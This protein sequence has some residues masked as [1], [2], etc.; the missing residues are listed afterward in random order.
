MAIF[1][2][3]RLGD[4]GILADPNP[5]DLPPNA[6]SQGNNL[7]FNDGKISRSPVFK[8]VLNTT[9]SSPSFLFTYLQ[10]GQVDKVGIANNDGSLYF[11][12][13]G[14]EEDVTP[15]SFTPIV[16]DSPH[17]F[18]S[19][20]N[21]AYVNRDTAAPMY[22]KDGSTD[23]DELP[24][25]PA[26]YTCKVLRSFKSYLIAL[27]I[28]KPTSDNPTMVKWSDIALVNSYPA[29][30]DETDPANSAGENTITEADSEFLDGL[31][32]RDA[33]VLYTEN[34]VHMME[35]TADNDVFRF[36]KLWDNIGIMNTNCVVEVEGRHYVFGR[37]DIYVHDG[38]SYQSI[39]RGK[40]HKY[41]YGNL[42]SDDR[43]R[44]F[45]AHNPYLTEIYFCYVSA[46]EQANFIETTYCNKAA[47]FN[48]SNGT[49]AFRDLPN[50]AGAT[51]ASLSTS[52]TY[53]GSDPLTYDEA[54]GSYSNMTDNSKKVM[55]MLS[56]Q[57]TTNNL[58]ASRL[59]AHDEITGG[60]VATALEPEATKA[61]WIERIGIDLDDIGEQLRA[62][63]VINTIYPQGSSLAGAAN[64]GFSFGAT[65][66][67][68]D[69]PTFSAI[70]YFSP[71]DAYKVNSRAAGRYLAWRMLNDSDYDHELSGMD[72]EVVVT[73]RR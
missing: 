39:I 48:Y 53:D 18:C 64:M 12:S 44:F 24:N 73:G 33:F 70:Q 61:S 72:V 28:T 58:T 4:I 9:A 54:G 29:T 21:V 27:N 63:K 62:Y 5:Y 31:P 13:N 10:A 15:A 65:D 2:L 69:T 1:P 38:I 6:L 26:D 57:D 19:L 46:D 20:A 43:G 3:R 59:F 50:S 68:E 60:M 35:Y 71:P 22:Y 34:Q 42:I 23:F 36:R 67:V 51:Y 41:V 45:V 11:Y 25:W 55:F 30:W 7:R 14:V 52:F 8:T 40:N 49:W 16:S 32:L 56:A 47:V 37:K 17:T 66:Y